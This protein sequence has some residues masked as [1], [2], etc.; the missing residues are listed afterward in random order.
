M[1]TIITYATI[2]LIYF[3]LGV[4]AV[5]AGEWQL[6]ALPFMVAV[7]LFG[8]GISQALRQQKAQDRSI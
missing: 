3:M 4:L 7:T 5:S 6:S 1:S 2:V 8:A